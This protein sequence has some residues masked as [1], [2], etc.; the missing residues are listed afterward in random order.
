MERDFSL[1]LCKKQQ[2]YDDLLLARKDMLGK[3]RYLVPC[4]KRVNKP[5]SQ[6]I[7]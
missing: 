5:L 4:R 7:F 2:F 3:M 1:V 6:Q